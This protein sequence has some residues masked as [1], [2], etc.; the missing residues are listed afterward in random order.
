MI[1]LVFPLSLIPHLLTKMHQKQQFQIPLFQINESLLDSVNDFAR[2][3][4]G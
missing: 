4:T 1:I 2:P 3:K